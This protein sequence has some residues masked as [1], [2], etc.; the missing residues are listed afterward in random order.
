MAN[1]PSLDLA[2]AA[3]I[4]YL[5][6]IPALNTALTTPS[7]P[8]G[9]YSQ[10][11]EYYWQGTDFTYPA[12][13]LQLGSA[14]P[15]VPEPRCGLWKLPFYIMCFSENKS[16]KECSRLASIIVSA[17]HGFQSGLMQSI[18][19]HMFY[20]DQVVPPIRQDEL[21][22]RSE[23]IAHTSMDLWAGQF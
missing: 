18:D 23:V 12:V 13:R 14:R 8:S 7:S 2:Q 15:E 1:F 9:S 11:K 17:I 19:F 4:T 3:L 6:S 21:T 22:W 5:K 10:I 20:V 16:S